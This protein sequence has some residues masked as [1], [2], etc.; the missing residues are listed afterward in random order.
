MK[1]FGSP[2][3]I[4][5]MLPVAPAH[6]DLLY[7]TQ[8]S[9]LAL[10]VALDKAFFP[11]D[12]AEADPTAG[13]RWAIS[14]IATTTTPDVLSAQVKR[15][16]QKGNRQLNNNPEDPSEKKCNYSAD[17]SHVCLSADFSRKGEVGEADAE[18]KR[19]PVGRKGE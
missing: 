19:S 3:I 18:N 15:G 6:T 12:K 9:A 11:G 7:P 10:L 17:G 5:H 16:L 14:S 4:L 1:R 13:Q 8:L 2:L